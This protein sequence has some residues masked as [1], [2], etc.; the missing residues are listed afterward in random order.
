VLRAHERPV[1]R[2]DDRADRHRRAR[3]AVLGVLDS[4]AEALVA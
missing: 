1:P 4:L 3:A 2:D